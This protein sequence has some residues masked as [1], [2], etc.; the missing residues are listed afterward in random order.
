[1]TG[2]ITI[3]TRAGDGVNDCITL[4]NG[5]GRDILHLVF[6]HKSLHESLAEERNIHGTFRIR[7]GSRFGA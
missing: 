7:Q 6:G 5:Q 3:K 2:F 4:T 1:M